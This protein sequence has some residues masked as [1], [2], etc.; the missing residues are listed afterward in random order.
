MKKII[1]SSAITLA[2]LFLLGIAIS[3][4]QKTES[5]YLLLNSDYKTWFYEELSQ[6]ESLKKWNSKFLPDIEWGKAVETK[7][8]F[9]TQ[10]WEIPYKSEMSYFF[11]SKLKKIGDES[12]TPESQLTSEQWEKPLASKILIIKD[13]SGGYTLR[14]VSYSSVYYDSVPA[15]LTIGSFLD[16]KGYS[17]SVIGIDGKREYVV[18]KALDGVV[19]FGSSKNE[20]L[21]NLNH[22]LN[23]Q[24]VT[25]RSCVTITVTVEVFTT[26]GHTNTLTTPNEWGLMADG[27]A[28]SVR[29]FETYHFTYCSGTN[30]TDNSSGGGDGGTSNNGDGNPNGDVNTEDEEQEAIRCDNC[31]QTPKLQTIYNDY[32]FP[33]LQIGSFTVQCLGRITN[34]STGLF[35][36]THQYS[37]SG[38]ID[39]NRSKIYVTERFKHLNPESSKCEWYVKTRHIVYYTI[40]PPATLVWASFP[41]SE[42]AREVA[43]IQWVL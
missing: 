3:A 8:F 37:G 13:A 19:N 34:C 22:S 10:C 42:R 35:A 18:F 21:A 9:G 29:H 41:P 32:Y 14:L 28:N 43:P 30:T 24:S 7:D 36:G 16:H 1:F 17:I 12:L 15:S 6:N 5:E 40:Q 25:F 39:G 4:C 23:S 38:S 26:E 27:S 20:L 31:D 11:A 33:P 2:T